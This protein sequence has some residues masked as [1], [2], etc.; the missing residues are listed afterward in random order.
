MAA[1]ADAA[2]CRDLLRVGSKS[3]YAA[4]LLLP[5]RL[6]RDVYSLYAFCRL[7]DDEVD[8]GGGPVAAVALLRERLEALYAGAPADG[9]VE[10]AFAALVARRG[11][12]MD[13]PAALIEGF[14]WDAEERRHET[15]SDVRAYGVRVAGVVGMMMTLLMGV[16]SAEALARAC[17]LGVAM[18]LTN[19]ARDVGEDARS[20]RLYLPR[21]WFAQ[22]GI[23]ADA[24]LA[25]PQ[26]C[27]AVAR[28]TDR[29]LVE[30]DVL[31]RR[32]ESGIALLPRDARPAIWAARR[33]YSE[34]GAQTRRNGL[35]NVNRRAIVSKSRKV[36]LLVRAVASSMFGRT[37]PASPPLSEAAPFVIAAARVDAARPSLGMRM[38][39]AIELLHRLEETERA[40]FAERGDKPAV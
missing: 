20:G 26:A 7:A 12:P 16:R 13:L 6:R 4:S 17:D 19:I 29:L 11:I 22:E 9:P 34:I 15:L 38:T 23:D 1:R 24:W 28:M 33:I 32:S 2:A 8:L 14:A 18:Q 39:W 40:R 36:A 35:D 31:Y 27:A 5:R 30:A 3:F 37:K 10:R 21:E 25:D